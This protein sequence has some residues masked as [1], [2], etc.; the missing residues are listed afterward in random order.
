MI[1]DVRDICNVSV[2]FV[3]R[4]SAIGDYVHVP[5]HGLLV[6]MHVTSLMY[7]PMLPM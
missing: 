1:A 5:D 3:P 4:T 7:L 6:A 2:P